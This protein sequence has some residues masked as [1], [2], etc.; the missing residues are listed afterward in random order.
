MVSRTLVIGSGGGSA[1]DAAKAIAVQL[2]AQAGLAT[3][4]RRD[5]VPCAPPVVAIPTTA[6][7]F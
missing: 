7:W 2:A 4:E 6:G 5:K 3:F 1:R